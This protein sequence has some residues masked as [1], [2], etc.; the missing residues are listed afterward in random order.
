MAMSEIAGTGRLVVDSTAST[1]AVLAEPGPTVEVA[2]GS[3]LANWRTWL[4]DLPPGH[5]PVRVSVGG[6]MAADLIATVHPGQV[7]TVYYE[8]RGSGRLSH[9]PKVR[10]SDGQRV[11]IMAALGAVAM[12]VLSMV[13]VAVMI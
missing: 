7:T 5:H 13:I 3:H 1:G 10:L 2:G 12:L 9:V 8:A 4:I 11:I 6:R